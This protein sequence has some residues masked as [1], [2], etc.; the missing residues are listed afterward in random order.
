MS[1]PRNL[2]KIALSIIATILAF[3]TSHLD[4]AELQ[5]TLAND[6]VSSN[7]RADDLYTSET[8]FE[9]TISDRSL[10]FS[11]RMFTDRVQGVRFD[12]TYA[13]YGFG[14]MPLGEWKIEPE[15]GLLH[16][17]HGLLGESVQNEVHEATGSDI[18]ELP[19]IG[20]DSFHF[21]G[22]IGLHR[23]LNTSSTVPLS[24]DVLAST[25]PGFRSSAEVR[26]GT[27]RYIGSGLTIE[28]GAGARVDLVESE[29]LDDVVKDAGFT[30]DFAISWRGFALSYSHNRYGTQSNHVTLGWRAG[31]SR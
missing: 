29:W 23:Q 5:F 19:Y 2:H 30:A 20:N 8:S 25:A 3:V 21:T 7:D 4:A 11:E 12:E 27:S 1:D 28:L 9:L 6:P 16:V 13:T 17:G 14:S 18:I 31:L 10:T 15:V 26:V 22:A 24:V